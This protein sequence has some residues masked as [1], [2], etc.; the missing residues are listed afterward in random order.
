[1]IVD[2]VATE[3]TEHQKL[4]E[5]DLAA[6][7]ARIQSLEKDQEIQADLARRALRERVGRAVQSIGVVVDYLADRGLIV[8]ADVQAYIERHFHMTNISPK[9]GSAREAIDVH[10]WLTWAD[11]TRSWR[12]RA[13]RPREASGPR[14]GSGAEVGGGPAELGVEG[15]AG[16]HR[17]DQADPVKV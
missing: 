7:L 3:L 2:Q 11:S 5:S 8:K 4:R 6:L 1:M 9:N 14:Q 12:E 17:H 15:E 10:S 13:G 16:R